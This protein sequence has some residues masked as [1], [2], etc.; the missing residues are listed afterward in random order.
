M[1]RTFSYSKF[2]NLD[3]V[4]LWFNPLWKNSPTYAKC[5]GE[6]ERGGTCSDEVWNHMIARIHFLY[7]RRSRLSAPPPPPRRNA[8]TQ[9]LSGIITSV[10]ALLCS[11]RRVFMESEAAN[12]TSALKKWILAV[13]NFIA[14]CPTSLNFS[15]TSGKCWGIFLEWIEPKD[16]F[17]VQEFRI[18]KF[19]YHVLYVL[20]KTEQNVTIE[21]FTVGPF[22]LWRQRMNA[23]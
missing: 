4:A 1:I 16:R 6:I 3:T 5:I 10:Q 8:G 18:R 17:Q 13:S 14:I 20:H 7:G 12:W 22:R 23:P 21:R 11:L 9:A 19:P 2:L 15:N